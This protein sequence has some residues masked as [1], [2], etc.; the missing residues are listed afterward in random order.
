MQEAAWR[1]VS[2]L[3][4]TDAAKLIYRDHIKMKHSSR[5]RLKTEVEGKMQLAPRAKLAKSASQACIQNRQCSAS[6][7]EAASGADI[8]SKLLVGY[9]MEARHTLNLFFWC[10]CESVSF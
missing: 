5:K 3:G 6:E 7:D 9:V 4:I 8:L 1:Y 10:E 2:Q